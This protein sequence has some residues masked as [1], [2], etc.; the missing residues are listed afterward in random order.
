MSNSDS[1]INDTS[2]DFGSALAE[3]RKS[4]KYTVDDV[5]RHLKIPASIISAIESSDVARLPPPTFAKGYMRA[6]AKFLEIPEDKVLDL[7]NQAVPYNHDAKLKSR[8]NLPHEKNSQSPLVKT[9][10]T[11]LIVAGFAAVIYGS[12]EY[13]QKKADVIENELESKDHSFS[14]NSLDS[15]GMDSD[16]QDT[17]RIEQNARLTG[18]DELILQ[19]SDTVESMA[20]EEPPLDEEQADTAASAPTDVSVAEPAPRAETSP[21]MAQNSDQQT[22]PIDG[23]DTIEF[24][25]ENGS[26]MEVRDANDTRLFYN[27]LPEGGGKVLHGLAPFSVSMGNARTTKVVI[28][29]LEIDLSAYI[30]GNNTAKFKVSSEQ[31]NVVFH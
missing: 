12:F 21:D 31:E 13:Y 9:V 2:C 26:W 29:G 11:F 8:S 16:D 7:Y 17:A 23:P 15:P 4:Q 28:N 19:G 20:Q 1:D 14:G 5:S 22:V 3:S 27:L 10:T 30:R 25:A 24:F 18:D 6:Y